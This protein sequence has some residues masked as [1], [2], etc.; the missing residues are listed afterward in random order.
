MNTYSYDAAGRVHSVGGV[1]YVYNAEGERVAKENSSGQVTASYVLGPG[2]AQVAEVNGSGQWQHSNVYALGQII[3][4]YDASG[5]RFQLDDAQGSRRVQANADGTVGL[6][7][8]TYPYGDGLSCSGPDEDATEQHFTGKEYDVESGNYYFGARYDAD[9]Y[10]RF[11]TPDWSATAEPVPY[12]KLDD[13]QSLNLYSYVLNNP[14]G[15]IDPDGHCCLDE[16]I[17]A[18]STLAGGAYGTYTGAEAGALGGTLW[19]P[20]AGLW[21]AVSLVASVGG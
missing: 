7:C 12:A 20:V 15:G 8:F 14:L 9:N 17:V 18:L 21:E 3:A 19:S 5:T 4:T 6:S 2:G 11:L 16:T 13:P 10:G 1:M